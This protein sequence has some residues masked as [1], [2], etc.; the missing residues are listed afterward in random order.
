MKEAL[1]S[2][3]ALVFSC[4]VDRVKNEVV[5]I[6]KE[7]ELGKEENSHAHE[8]RCKDELITVVGYRSNDILEIFELLLESDRLTMMSK[9]IKA[10]NMSRL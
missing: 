2:I 3:A 8:H 9:S 4:R 5:G 10:M 1:N 6:L 7:T